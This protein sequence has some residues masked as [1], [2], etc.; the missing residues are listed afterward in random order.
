MMC[1]LLFIDAYMSAVLPSDVLQPPSHQQAPHITT[2]A[3]GD[4]SKGMH[5]THCAFTLA[6][7]S[8]SASM[9]SSRPLNAAIVSAVCFVGASLHASH[10]HLVQSIHPPVNPPLNQSTVSETPRPRTHRELVLPGQKVDPEA[11][12][13]QALSAGLD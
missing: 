2:T 12:P 5:D 1:C 8:S 11:S 13:R 9:T 3:N 7:R 6:L 4:A 10:H